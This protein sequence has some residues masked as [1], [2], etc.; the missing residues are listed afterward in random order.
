[1]C[2]EG[3]KLTHHL[4]AAALCTPSRAAFMTGRYPIRMGIKIY[5]FDTILNSFL[6]NQF[7][8]VYFKN[9]G[10]AQEEGGAPVIMYTS[11][12]AGLPQTETTWAKDLQNN[13]YIT[14]AVG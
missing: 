6:E 8:Y 14:Q 12:K 7:M 5:I 9:L 11:G 4:S 13:G 10:L 2:S 1:M 3:I